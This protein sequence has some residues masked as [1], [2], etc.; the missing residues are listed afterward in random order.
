MTFS[1]ESSNGQE[2]EK[3]ENLG[4]SKEADGR[5][6]ISR[7]FL[8]LI[9]KHMYQLAAL[10]VNSNI[11]RKCGHRQLLRSYSSSYCC[12][13]EK[14][15]PTRI[16]KIFWKIC[17]LL[18]LNDVTEINS[19]F[20]LSFLLLVLLLEV[21]T[22]KIFLSTSLA[23]QP[24]I[25]ALPSI[26]F[27]VAAWLWTTGY[28]SADNSSLPTGNLGTYCKGTEYSFLELSI[29]VQQSISG[30]E[31]L[32]H[33]WRHIRQVRL[34]DVSWVLNLKLKF[35]ILAFQWYK[36]ATAKLRWLPLSIS[37]PLRLKP[38]KKNISATKRWYDWTAVFTFVRALKKACFI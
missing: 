23:A 26:G 9:G 15:P 31:T 3:K 4:N 2:Y 7:G 16:I 21:F 10:S 20:G 37:R 11:I 33:H 12:C 36:K 28:S 8:P 35:S 18:C 14:D 6:Y 25:A 29:N 22:N 19:V 1:E 30:I 17:K 38:E 5:K 27:K 13:L 24:E 34:N 32:F